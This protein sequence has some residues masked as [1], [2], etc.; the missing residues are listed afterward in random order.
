[1]ISKLGKTLKKNGEVDFYLK[2][3]CNVWKN[4]LKVIAILCKTQSNLNSYIEKKYP[5]H[6]MYFK[7]FLF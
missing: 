2:I 6:E 5:F 7:H 1:M 4:M 3:V